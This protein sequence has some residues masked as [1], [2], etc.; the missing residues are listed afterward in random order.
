M[1]RRWPRVLGLVAGGWVFQVA[2]CA[3]MDI[4]ELVAEGFRDT[5]VQISTYYIDLLVNNAWELE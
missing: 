5:A 2:G 1:R 4:A 3:N